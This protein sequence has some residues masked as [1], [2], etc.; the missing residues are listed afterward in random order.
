MLLSQFL[1]I[2]RLP[3]TSHKGCWYHRW[4]E[5]LENHKWTNCRCNRLWS[6]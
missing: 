3:E 2:Q 6:G 5:R 4:P 1:L